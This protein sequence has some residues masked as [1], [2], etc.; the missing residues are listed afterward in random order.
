MVD[1]NSGSTRV[2]MRRCGLELEKKKNGLTD[3]LWALREEDQPP[4]VALQGG[5]RNQTNGMR[6][7]KL[8]IVLEE[9]NFRGCRFLFA[10]HSRSSHLRLVESGTSIAISA[11][12][13][14]K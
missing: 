8:K 13:F 10:H 5:S 1:A 14:S 2:G 11:V 4:G 9:K 3:T 12:S 6:G 7:D